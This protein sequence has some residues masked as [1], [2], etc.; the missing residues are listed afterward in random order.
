MSYIKF[1]GAFLKA[2]YIQKKGDKELREKFL[3]LFILKI[4]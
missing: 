2:T 4:I 3:G 1:Y